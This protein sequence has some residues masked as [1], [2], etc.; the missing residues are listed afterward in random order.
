MKKYGFTKHKKIYKNKS[1]TIL[2]ISSSP[3]YILYYTPN[4]KY[5]KYLVLYKVRNKYTHQVKL[6][7]NQS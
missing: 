4:L 3:S 5:V 2:S 6:Y 7:V 1:Q